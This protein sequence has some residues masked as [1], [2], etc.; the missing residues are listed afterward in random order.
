MRKQEIISA[1]RVAGLATGPHIPAKEDGFIRKNA[2]STT[3]PMTERVKAFLRRWSLGRSFCCARYRRL[4]SHNETIRGKKGEG[5]KKKGE[6]KKERD[7]RYR[8]AAGMDP[9]QE[10]SAEESFSPARHRDRGGFCGFFLMKPSSSHG[11]V[12]SRGQSRSHAGGRIISCFRIPHSNPNNKQAIARRS[13]SG[14]LIDQP[15]T[16]SRGMNTAGTGERSCRSAP[17]SPGFHASC[18]AP[19]DGKGTPGHARRSALR[20]PRSHPSSGRT[21]AGFTEV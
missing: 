18:G 3:I 9:G 11:M 8:G 10:A 13:S 6:K 12:R 2:K 15:A 1:R 20:F 17:S 14:C 16:S 7:R 5:E 19:P 21:I 4:S